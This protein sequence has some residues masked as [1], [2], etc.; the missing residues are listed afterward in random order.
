M[1]KCPDLQIPRRLTVI[2]PQCRWWCLLRHHMENRWSQPNPPMTAQHGLVITNY[3][4]SL[5]LLCEPT[6]EHPISG[7]FTYSVNFSDFLISKSQS[8]LINSESLKK[9]LRF[10]DSCIASE[11]KTYKKLFWLYYVI[12]KTSTGHIKKS[13]HRCFSEW[14]R[15]KN[16]CPT[17]RDKLISFIFFLINY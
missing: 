4:V 1:P 17:F 2:T 15:E 10:R 9:N 14:E 3:M 12:G 16:V 5:I 13:N 11:I 7:T 8:Y 6:A